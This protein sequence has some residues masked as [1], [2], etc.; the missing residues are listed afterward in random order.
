[1]HSLSYVDFHVT[2]TALLYMLVVVVVVV[3]E[4]V[5][6]VLREVVVFQNLNSIFPLYPPTKVGRGCRMSPTPPPV[7]NLR[8][9][10]CFHFTISCFVCLPTP[11]ALSVLAF[12]SAY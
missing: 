5:A 4:I 6:V 10:I 9:V 12:F 2:Y 8:A 1:M 11:I 3:V 7:W